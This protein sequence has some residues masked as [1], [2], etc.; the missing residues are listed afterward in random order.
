LDQSV[1][2][3]VGKSVPQGCEF[4]NQSF[5]LMTTSAG[6]LCFKQAQPKMCHSPK[7]DDRVELL[8]F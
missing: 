3:I 4:E 2:K 5:N 1:K 7:V 8:F 6:H